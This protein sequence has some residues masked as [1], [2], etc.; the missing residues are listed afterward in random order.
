MSRK[1]RINFDNRQQMRE[2]LFY[3]RGCSQ[4]FKRQFDT[5]KRTIISL[6]LLGWGREKIMKR[7]YP[8]ITEYQIRQVYAEIP[9]IVKLRNIMKQLSGKSKYDAMNLVYKALD[10]N[11]N[12]SKI[13]GTD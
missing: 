9:C 13:G 8:R 12:I 1:Y 4:E 7:S 3:Y 11:G 5:T 6:N 2:Y 10:I